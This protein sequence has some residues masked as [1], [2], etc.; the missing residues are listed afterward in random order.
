MFVLTDKGSLFVYLIEEKAPDRSD[1]FASKKSAFTGNLLLEKPI[2]V[3]DL[4]PLK[5]I[6]TGLDHFLG[7]D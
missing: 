1:P 4:P 6:G 7:L 5:Q 3:K 2:Q